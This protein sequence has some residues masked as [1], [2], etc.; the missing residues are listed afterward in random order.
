MSYNL[1]RQV[2]G[3]IKWRVIPAYSVASANF[4]YYIRSFLLYSFKVAHIIYHLYLC[5]ISS[6]TGQNFRL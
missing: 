6:K 3:E 1:F 2:S 4:E 5:L